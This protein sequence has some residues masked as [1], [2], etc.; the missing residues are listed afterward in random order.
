MLVNTNSDIGV[1]ISYESW[2]EQK[3]NYIWKNGSTIY[4]CI[5]D[6]CAGMRIGIDV[7]AVKEALNNIIN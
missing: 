1:K 6:V 3:E 7:S 5:R 2:P 4:I